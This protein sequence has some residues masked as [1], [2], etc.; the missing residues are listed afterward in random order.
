MHSVGGVGRNGGWSLAR[1]HALDPE[2]S[3][4]LTS[5]SEW[6]AIAKM[7]LQRQRLMDVLPKKLGFGSTMILE[8]QMDGPGPQVQTCS[9]TLAEAVTTLSPVSLPTDVAL[10][11][12]EAGRAKGE[13][14]GAAQEKFRKED[15]GSAGSDA[16]AR[17][18]T[19]TRTRRSRT[20]RR[21]G[22]PKPS[23]RHDW[24]ESRAN[25]LDL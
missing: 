7:E 19:P 22:S 23:L 8:A 24:G 18:E 16:P 3:V 25:A 12:R 21:R 14:E 20:R 1:L 5:Q 9:P 13:S 10:R 4:S 6:Q 17:V 11:P 15:R 2:G